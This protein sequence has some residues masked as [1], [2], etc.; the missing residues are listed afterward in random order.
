MQACAGL[1]YDEMFTHGG[2]A[3]NW[4]TDPVEVTRNEDSETLRVEATTENVGAHAY[5]D[6]ICTVPVGA[7]EKKQ[8]TLTV[9]S[10]REST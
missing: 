7:T 3:I 9:S 6:W 10:F 4:E 1:S 2:L 5:L 8:A